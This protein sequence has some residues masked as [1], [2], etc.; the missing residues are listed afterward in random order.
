MATIS[1]LITDALTS[2]GQAGQGQSISPEMA[3]QGLRVTNRF[4]EEWSVQRLLQYY[5]A[6]RTFTLTG[7]TGGA[8]GATTYTGSNGGNGGA[9]QSRVQHIASW[10]GI[11][12]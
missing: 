7:G 6:T 4:M 3:Q 12:L 2:I 1:D 9:G 8:G 11:S 5:I 10:S